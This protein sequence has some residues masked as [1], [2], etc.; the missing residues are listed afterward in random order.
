VIQ[1]EMYSDLELLIYAQFKANL[2]SIACVRRSCKQVIFDNTRN[3]FIIIGKDS[4][5][6][7]FEEKQ[8]IY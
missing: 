6:Y 4:N 1:L 2:L 8:S 3:E 7:V 5:R